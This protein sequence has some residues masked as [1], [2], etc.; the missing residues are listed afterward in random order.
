MINFNTQHRLKLK[1]LAAMQN[2]PRVT[3]DDFDIIVKAVSIGDTLKECQGIL[4]S[5]M[6]NRS[7]GTTMAHFEVLEKVW[8][9]C[10]D[11]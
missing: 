1:R 7:K 3:N 11:I 5:C 10:T 8:R 2:K 9:K 4:R 6:N